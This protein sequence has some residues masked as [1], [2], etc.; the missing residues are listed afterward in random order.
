MSN[1]NKI[2]YNRG[3]VEPINRGE[4]GD[5]RGSLE[6]WVNGPMVV[7]TAPNGKK[8]GHLNCNGNF[9]KSSGIPYALGDVQGENGNM[10]V[11]VTVWEPLVN[12][13]EKMNLDKGM[14][15][16]VYGRYTVRNYTRKDGNPGKNVE[17]TARKI[18]L[19]YPIAEGKFEQIGG[20]VDREVVDTVGKA[21]GSLAMYLNGPVSIKTTAANNEVGE[22]NLSGRFL[23]NSGIPY[24]LGEDIL[25][26]KDGHMFVRASAWSFVLERLK[27]LNLQKGALVQIYGHFEVE[28]FTREDGTKGKSV[29]CR[30]VKQFDVLSF[31]KD[32]KPAA[33]SDAVPAAAAPAPEVPDEGGFQPPKSFGDIV[34]PF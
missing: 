34:V 25:D 19:K 17:C 1:E 8:V 13:I 4:Q 2:R 12:A 5:A 16:Q 3:F 26:P 27:K 7:E 30:D 9:P 11:R 15:I 29:V 23:A 10:F 33:Q 31:G 6:L 14:R 28:E 22:M 24:A 32:R 20:C 18:E 21:V